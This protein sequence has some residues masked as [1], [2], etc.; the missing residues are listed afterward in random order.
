MSGHSDVLG[1]DG[2]D[3]EAVL[4]SCAAPGCSVAVRDGGDVGARAFGASRFDMA[5]P[6]TQTARLPAC[7]MSKPVAVLGALR[8]VDAG[9]LD[10]DVD[11]SQYL[12]RWILPPNGDWRPRL[13]LRQLASHT[14]GLTAHAGFPGYQ[15][16]APLPSLVEVLTGAHPANSPG[17]RV[18]LL[19]G[20]QFR[21]SGHGAT[22]IQLLIE[23]VTGVS[24]S[25]ILDQL[26]L[27]PLGLEHSTFV[28]ELDDPERAHGHLAGGCQVAGGWRIQPEYCAA[29]LWTTP[30]DYLRFMTSVQDSYAGRPSPIVS[31]AAAQAMLTPHADLHTGR[32]MLGMTHVGLGFFLTVRHGEPAWFGHTGSNT[33]FVCASMADVTGQR[34]AVVMVNS[35]NGAPV[36]KL[37]LQAIARARG[38]VDAELGSPSASSLPRIDVRVGTYVAE[39]GLSA[40]LRRRGGETELILVGQPP[41]QLQI[42]DENTLSTED[43]DLRLRLSPDGSISLEQGGHA[44]TLR[45]EP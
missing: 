37:L 2:F 29:G 39:S 31:H 12:T 35:D 32:D 41:M 30:S 23:E 1:L 15:R 26:V 8:L 4:A 17:A 45:P 25:D 36:A 33:G 5:V 14:A 18:D 40:E 21:Y 20:V 16:G 44:T 11:I 19:P 7:S 24:A 34:G 43:L 42:D 13:T 38:W 28:Q 10:L 6:L 9:L 27:E 3:V 22:I